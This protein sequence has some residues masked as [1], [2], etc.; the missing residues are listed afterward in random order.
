LNGVNASELPFE[1]AQKCLDW[2]VLFELVEGSHIPNIEL[3]V[4]Y[5]LSF[6][7]R[8]HYIRILTNE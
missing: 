5:R 8:T 2:S 6:P 3:P 1:E 7:L 4:R